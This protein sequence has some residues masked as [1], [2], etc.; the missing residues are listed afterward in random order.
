MM[1]LQNITLGRENIFFCHVVSVIS[2]T[3]S[4]T[5]IRTL[6]AQRPNLTLTYQVSQ[7]KPAAAVKINPTDLEISS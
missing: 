7:G 4:L 2:P 6:L 5:P 3:L 1:L